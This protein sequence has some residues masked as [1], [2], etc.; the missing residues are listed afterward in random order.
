MDKRHLSKVLRQ[1]RRHSRSA[2]IADIKMHSPRDGKLLEPEHIQAYLLQLLTGGVDALSIVTASRRFGGSLDVTRLVSGATHLPLM[3]KDYFQSVEQI[4]ES[5]ELGFTAVHLTLQTIG[6]LHLVASLKDR[7]EQLGL[8]VV[9]GIHTFEEL[10]QALALQAT[11]IGINNR[12][13]KDL[14]TDAG[15]VSLTEKL[16]PLVPRGVLLI[17]ESSLMSPGE[18]ARAWIAGAD[19]VLVGTAFAKSLDLQSTLR[20]FLNAHLAPAIHEHI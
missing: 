15:T 19:A 3:R 5:L 7:A 1:T 8:E 18:V 20:A 13:I 17:S 6:D 12:S 11:M 9:V 14:E 4:D 16:A 10:N 2:V